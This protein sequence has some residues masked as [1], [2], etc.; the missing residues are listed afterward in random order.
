[1]E[2]Q[3]TYIRADGDYSSKVVVSFSGID[4]DESLTEPVTGRV[5]LW[6][7]DAVPL[8]A[9]CGIDDIQDDGDAPYVEFANREQR[10]QRQSQLPLEFDFTTNPSS[11]TGGKWYFYRTANWS[12]DSSVDPYDDPERVK[13]H[14]AI[15]SAQRIRLIHRILSGNSESDTISDLQTLYDA[16]PDVTAD[17][18]SDDVKNYVGFESRTKIQDFLMG[19]TRFSRGYS[20]TVNKVSK[21]LVK[22]EYRHRVQSPDDIRSMVETVNSQ[23]HFPEITVI[24]VVKSTVKRTDASELE[25]IADQLGIDDWSTVLS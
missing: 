19:N 16:G 21:Q 22:E 17:E 4:V 10:F 1:M 5:L 6:V 9:E 20:E 7:S 2:T 15:P 11:E 23:R 12:P 8:P 3:R 14:I 18:F 13:H 24:D 25:E